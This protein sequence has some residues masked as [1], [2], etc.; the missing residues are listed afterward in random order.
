[1]A[2]EKLLA[3]LRSLRDHTTVAI[4][5]VERGN[6]D[7]AVEELELAQAELREATKEGRE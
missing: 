2:A 7:A 4:R 5:D 3:L 6:Y 1:V